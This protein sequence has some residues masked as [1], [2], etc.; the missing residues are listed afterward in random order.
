M[1]I[2]CVYNTLSIRGSVWRRAWDSNPEAI[3]DQRFSRPSDYQLSQL[4]ILQR[5]FCFFKNNIS[6]QNQA[7]TLKPGMILHIFSLTENI[8][9]RILLIV[10]RRIL[11]LIPYINMERQLPVLTLLIAELSSMTHHSLHLYGLETVQTYACIKMKN[12]SCE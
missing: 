3:S 6:S 12:I 11:H 7:Y 2:V 9:Q 8:L 4:S 1:P 5:V 10:G